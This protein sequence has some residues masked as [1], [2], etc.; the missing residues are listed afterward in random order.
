MPNPYIGNDEAA[1]FVEYFASLRMLRDSVYRLHT[2]GQLHQVESR[3]RA[4]AAI[5]E[6]SF[7]PRILRSQREIDGHVNKM[8][9][10]EMLRRQKKLSELA[11]EIYHPARRRCMS[12]AELQT[13]VHHMYEEQ[14]RLREQRRQQ[15]KLN[16]GILTKEEK[17][18][19]TKRGKELMQAR[20]LMRQR[21]GNWRT[22]SAHVKHNDGDLLLVSQVPISPMPR[23]SPGRSSRD[24]GS[25]LRKGAHIVDME[26][27]KRL[28]EPLRPR[29]KFQR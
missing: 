21:E 17:E 7:P 29:S 3:R 22:P 15:S 16:L 13:H 8:V 10:E 14:M 24:G 11:W 20:E 5:I 23:S 26:R 2:V 9:H 27:L 12:K 6:Y 25:P 18:A 1:R 19:K 4:R 28:A